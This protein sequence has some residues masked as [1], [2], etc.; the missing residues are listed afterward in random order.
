M[1]AWFLF[2]QGINDTKVLESQA[3]ELSKDLKAADDQTQLVLVAHI[4][5]MFAQVGPAPIDPSLR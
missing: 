4:G 5:H 2:V 3:I 1:T